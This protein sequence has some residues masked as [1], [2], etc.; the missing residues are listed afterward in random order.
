MKKFFLTLAVLLF[1]LQ[2]CDSV[3]SQY[4][5]FD[6]INY[7]SDFPKEVELEKANPVDIDLMGCVDFFGNDSVLVFK[8]MGLENHWKVCRIPDL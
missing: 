3:V 4:L 2:G 7:I 8:M 6:D 1:V 5:C